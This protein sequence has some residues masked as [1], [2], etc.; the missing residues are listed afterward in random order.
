MGNSPNKLGWG[1]VA[2]VVLLAANVVVPIVWGDI[3]P[4]TSGPMF[5]DAPAQCCTYRVFDSRGNELP[6]K[7][8]L[9]QRIYDGN[10]VGYGVGIRPPPVIEQQYGVIH[11]EAV[12]RAHFGRILARSENQRLAYVEVVQEVL[13][14]LPGGSVGIVRTQRWRIERE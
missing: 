11:D 4:F 10:P 3:Y 14:P 9:C 6:A 2:A 12:V 5:R 13:G 8:W 1:P 7:A